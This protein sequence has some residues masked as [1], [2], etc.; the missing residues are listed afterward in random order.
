MDS[1]F[2]VLLLLFGASLGSFIHALA[3][4]LC[5]DQPFINSRSHCDYCQHILQWFELIPIFSFFFLRGKCRKCSK[6]LSFWYPTTEIITGISVIYLYFLSPSF[7]FY[8]F[9]ISFFLIL[10]TIFIADAKYGLI[11]LPLVIVGSFLSLVYNFVYAFNNQL[12]FLLTGLIATLFFFSIHFFTKG[13]GMGLGDVFY[14]FFM[15]LILGFPKIFVGLYLA[16]LTG[17]ITSL[18]LILLGKKKLRGDTIPFG[19]FLVLGTIISLLFGEKLLIF[20]HSYLFYG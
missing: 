13:K 16:F 12:N 19:P 2:F 20:A 9:M 15:G 14:V 1:I 18:I 3:D 11:P 6:K 5:T 17:A 8:I 10:F 4:R 7:L